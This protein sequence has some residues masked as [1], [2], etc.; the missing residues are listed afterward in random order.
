MTAL[1]A[2]HHDETQRKLVLHHVK[3]LADLPT[4][5]NPDGRYFVAMLVCDARNLSVN[6]ISAAAR[7]LIDDGCAYFCCWGNDCER[8]HDVFDEE[9]VG[10]GFDDVSDDTIMTTWHDNEPLEK[11]IEFSLLHTQPPAKFQND[12][13]ALIAIVIDNA[14]QDSTIQKAW[15]NPDDFCNAN[16]G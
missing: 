7:K 6:K 12:C 16:D 1:F 11:F 9:W 3:S 13:N 10:N 14:E 2:G 15:A 4:I 5:L 8:V